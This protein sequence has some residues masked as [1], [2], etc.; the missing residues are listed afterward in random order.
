MPKSVKKIV[1]R[2]PTMKKKEI[3]EFAI[4]STEM[5]DGNKI[6]TTVQVIETKCLCKDYEGQDYF[7]KTH[8]PKV[9]C[10]KCHCIE[11]EVPIPDNAPSVIHYMCRVCGVFYM[12][13]TE[14]GSYN[15]SA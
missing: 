13:N 2:N 14:D 3:P 7:C 15:Y 6:A 4:V 12:R 8:T 11:S 10:P 9:E 5:T 1:R